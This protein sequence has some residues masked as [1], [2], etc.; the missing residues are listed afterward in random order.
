MIQFML[1][2]FFIGVVFAW[3]M[4]IKEEKEILHNANENMGIDNE[5]REKYY[6][7]DYYQSTKYPIE[8]VFGDKGK[9][10]EYF[11]EILCE[12]IPMKHRILFNL[13]I[14]EENGSFQ[15]IDAVCIIENGLVLL[16][17][18]KNRPG[19]YSG[20]ENN[21]INDIHWKQEIGSK[22]HEMY[23]PIMQNKYHGLALYKWLYDQKYF[24][25]YHDRISFLNMIIFVDDDVEFNFDK[26]EFA[27]I[28]T[29]GFFT[30]NAS[31]FLEFI[32]N[33][34]QTDYEYPNF[35]EDFY[36]YLYSYT[37]VDNVDQL[38]EQR[39]A[40][41]KDYKIRRFDKAKYFHVNCFPTV[42]FRYD[43]QYVEC[44]TAEN[45]S[46][47]LF[48]DFYGF[49]HDKD[50]DQWSVVKNRKADTSYLEGRNLETVLM[51]A[52]EVCDFINGNLTYQVKE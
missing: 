52:E 17:E 24:E 8:K 31:D 11:L 19:T 2:M 51:T 32:N 13:V 49:R 3:R 10:G 1:I 45:I 22:E 4:A 47:S 7:S 20:L 33:L 12:Q 36:D 43:G 38:M 35:V 6:Q 9:Y 15:E 14:P 27:E 41:I 5:Q 37:K 26:N 29:R 18:G 46:W 16:L 50:M 34:P 25:K 40:N 21:F 42:I 39:E 23:S 48:Y 30:G 28:E 44:T